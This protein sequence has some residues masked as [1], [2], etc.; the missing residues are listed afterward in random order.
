MTLIEFTD[1]HGNPVYLNPDQIVRILKASD[2]P[3]G[4][5]IDLVSG[6]Q[7]VREPVSTVLKFIASNR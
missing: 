7:I 2:I 6:L 3:N 5:R 4:T 1:P